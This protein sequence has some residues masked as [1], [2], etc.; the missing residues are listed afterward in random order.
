M[1]DVIWLVRFLLHGSNEN[2]LSVAGFV[3]A[4]A[5]AHWFLNRKPALFADSERVINRLAE[6]AKGKYRDLRPLR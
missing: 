2:P 1:D 5:L 6:E 4:Y 3:L